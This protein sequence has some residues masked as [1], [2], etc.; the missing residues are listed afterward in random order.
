MKRGPFSNQGTLI[1]PPFLSQ[2]RVPGFDTVHVCLCLCVSVCVSVC[3]CMCVCASMCL[4]LC[5]CLCVSL[6][7]CQCLCPSNSNKERPICIMP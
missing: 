3:L 6:C 2:V 1:C 5:V 7:V 4:A